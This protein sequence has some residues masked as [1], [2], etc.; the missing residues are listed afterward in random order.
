V[1]LAMATQWPPEV[2]SMAEIPLS[3]VVVYWTCHKAHRPW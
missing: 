1:A 3:L 2:Q